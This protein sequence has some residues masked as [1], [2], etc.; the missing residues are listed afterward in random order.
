MY[1]F[2]PRSDNYPQRARHPSTVTHRGSSVRWGPLWPLTQRM[3]R[4]SE[5]PQGPS[6]PAGVAGERLSDTAS[7]PSACASC[8]SCPSIVAAQGPLVMMVGPRVVWRSRSERHDLPITR[9]HT[10]SPSL[11]HCTRRRL[12]PGRS[13]PRPLITGAPGQKA[14]WPG[15]MASS[16][17]EHDG[18]KRTYATQLNLRAVKGGN[19]D[20]SLSTS[21]PWLLQSQRHGSPPR[22]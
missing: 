12:L 18:L 10:R 21:F 7:T 17:A 8:H 2:C 3:S 16:R 6:S 22:V 13:I 9:K 19:E 1:V 5:W 14:P 15:T 11:R 20:S 4:V